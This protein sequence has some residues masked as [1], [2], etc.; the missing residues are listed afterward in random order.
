MCW[1]TC[2]TYS[3]LAVFVYQLV[4]VINTYLINRFVGLTVIFATRQSVVCIRWNSMAY[5]SNKL[6]EIINPILNVKF[7]KR[8]P[9]LWGQCL[10]QLISVIDVKVSLILNKQNYLRSYLQCKIERKVAG[11]VY[12]SRRIQPCS[13][14]LLPYPFL[15]N[16]EVCRLVVFDIIS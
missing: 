16:V 14:L 15:R 9:E 12:L 3:A 7:K 4:E 1:W 11:R 8:A 10:K 5:N 6:I 2:F 13:Q